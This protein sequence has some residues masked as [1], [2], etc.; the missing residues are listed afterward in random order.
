MSIVRIGLALAGT[1]SL[2]TGIVTDV[3]TERVLRVERHHVDVEPGSLLGHLVF[4]IDFYAITDVDVQSQWARFQLTGLDP[5]TIT[6]QDI[7]LA[8]LIAEDH[9]ALE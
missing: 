3:G 6:V 4:Q 9:L 1:N 2:I 7:H 8:L 5:S